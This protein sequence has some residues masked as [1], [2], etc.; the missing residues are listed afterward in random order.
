MSDTGKQHSKKRK[1]KSFLQ[2]KKK[3]KWASKLDIDMSG[4]LITCNNRER[5][6]VREAYNLLNEYADRLFGPEQKSQTD[7]QSSAEEDNEDDIEEQMKKEITSMKEIKRDE[8]RFQ[9]VESGANNCIFIKTKVPDPNGL[10]SAIFADIKETGK[11]KSRFI[12]RL[13]PVM[14]TCKAVEDKIEKLAE[15]LLEPFFKTPGEGHSYSVLFKVRNNNS[16]GRKTVQHLLWKIIV[17]MS[18]QNRV[19]LQNPEYIINIDIIKNICCFSIIENYYEYR[20]YNLQEL[21][22]GKQRDGN[23]SKSAGDGPLK[24]SEVKETS[25]TG[26]TETGDNQETGMKG[27]KASDSLQDGPCSTQDLN[28]NLHEGETEKDKEDE[29]TLTNTSD[30]TSSTLVSP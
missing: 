5:E 13:M 4:F 20:K 16:I 10:A 28:T 9:Q 11:A 8:R 25:T 3:A 1:K 24:H 6:A 19:S 14:G 29:E 21:A 27:S 15:K 2:S 23:D 22:A 12:M 7:A 26:C 18:I 30:N 17:S